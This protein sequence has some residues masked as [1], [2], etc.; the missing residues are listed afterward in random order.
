MEIKNKES[1]NKK[2]GLSI[3][4]AI[5]ILF[6]VMSFVS[7]EIN[8]YAPV[9][10]GDIVTIKQVCAS[11]TYVNITISYPNSTIA[12]SN[13]AMV[14][15]GA[16]VWT[17]DFSNTSQLG[18]Y[19]VNGEGDL[20]G[21]A[22]GFDVLWFEVTPSGITQTTSQGIGSAIFLFLMLSL[23]I[24]FGWMGFR[25]SESKSLWILGIFFL[26]LSVLLIV[27]NVWLGVEY[28][29]NFTGLTNSAMPEIIFYIFMFLLV[30]GFLSGLALLFL[31]WK[32]LGRYIKKEIQKKK[33]DEEFDDDFN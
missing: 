14:S 26:F 5:I 33:E 21:V 28:H 7:A 29:R 27:Y 10:Q 16:G 11:C 1:I 24:L 3:L 13:Q 4:I 9:K 15:Q 32:E 6:F 12:I 8:N 30:S 20:N 2:I 17:Y 25:L 22:T 23:T 19:D 31:R 18:R